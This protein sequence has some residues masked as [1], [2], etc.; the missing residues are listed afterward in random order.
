MIIYFEVV[1][2]SFLSLF[3]W[4]KCSV[5]SHEGQVSG[6]MYETNGMEGEA[7]FL[8]DIGLCQYYDGRLLLL[9]GKTN[10]CDIVF[11]FS[12]K[13]LCCDFNLTPFFVLVN[14]FF[15][16]CICRNSRFVHSRFFA[17]KKKDTK[18]TVYVT[19]LF[20]TLRSNKRS[21]FYSSSAKS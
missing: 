10:C 20:L 5:S 7:Y 12:L 6:L 3:F 13:L 4:Q 17:V 8:S 15:N 11:I 18:K 14:R 9:Q 21:S 2:C 16:L 1:V 19:A